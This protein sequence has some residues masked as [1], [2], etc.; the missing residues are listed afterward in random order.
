MAKR[1]RPQPLVRRERKYRGCRSKA[2]A[3]IDSYGYVC[4]YDDESAASRHVRSGGFGTFR[5]PVLV[6]D[7]KFYRVTR[8][9]TPGAPHDRE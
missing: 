2:W 4:V 8:R 6:V 1:K 9:P 7:P 3:V 5:R